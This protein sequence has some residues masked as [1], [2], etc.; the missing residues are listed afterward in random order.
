[1]RER[2]SVCLFIGALGVNFRI[3]R[4]MSGSALPEWQEATGLRH[5]LPQPSG[6]S[7]RAGR[8]FGQDAELVALRIGERDPAATVG[9]PVIGEV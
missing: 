8:V 6:G 1:M 7:A 9:P 2:L 4:D 5:G 3:C